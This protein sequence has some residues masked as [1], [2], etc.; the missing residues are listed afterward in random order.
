[1]EAEKKAAAAAQEG[2]AKRLR[3][4]EARCESLEETVEELRVAM[5]R[6]RAA[7]DMR[8]ASFPPAACP[9]ETFAI[10]INER[11]SK[12]GLVASIALLAPVG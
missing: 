11:H 9:T 2:T 7:A 6:Q 10:Q 4:A 5:D 1:V 12:H 8:C 3:D